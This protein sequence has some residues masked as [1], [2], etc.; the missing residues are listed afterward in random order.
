MFVEDLSIAEIASEAVTYSSETSA[1]YT[2]TDNIKVEGEGY[3]PYGRSEF[4][5]WVNG[6]W[7]C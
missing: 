1:D 2:D 4:I 7:Y 6:D 5:F 3:N